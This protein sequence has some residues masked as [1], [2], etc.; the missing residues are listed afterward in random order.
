LQDKNRWPARRHNV[1]QKSA[2]NLPLQLDRSASEPLQDQ[3]FEKLRQLILSGRLKPNTRVIAT[4]F[5]AEQVGVSRRT[6]LFAYERLIAEGY[7]ETRPAIGT[8]VSPTPP[9]QAKLETAS[10]ALND[11][12]RQAALYPAS[13]RATNFDGRTNG[14]S[15]P[16]DFMP[17]R[18]DG[19]LVLPQ[20]IWL[21]WM[22]D[23][24]MSDPLVFG[25]PAPIGG[26][27][28]LREVIANYLGA[29]RGI[30]ASPDQIIIV[31]G[32][33]QAASL[34]AHLFQRQNDRVVVETP[35]DPAISDFFRLR[36]ASVM[37]VPVDS[38][39]LQI[40]CL[41]KGR[42]ALAYVT[43]ARQN[44]IGG[45]MPQSRRSEL[46]EWAREAGAYLIEDDCDGDLRH[47]GA[48]QAP[49]A[50]LD[51]YGLVFH[52]GSFAKTLGAGLA[53]GYL[54]VPPE[55][56]DEILA[57][58]AMAN[59]GGQHFEQLVVSNLIAGG[60]YD[61]HL[62]RLRKIYL[63]R[64]DALILA[65]K[66]RLGDITLL[67]TECG[68]QMSWVLPDDVVSASALH[69]ATLARGVR[70]GAIKEEAAQKSGFDDRTIVLG[71]PDL[72]TDRLREGV[73]I[74]A[75]AYQRLR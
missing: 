33:R 34:V 38:E 24:M 30:L 23:T 11:V 1:V 21:R 48:A 35:G 45:I 26:A 73:A 12:P 29:T 52:V 71:Y 69:Q 16:I 39:G 41:P 59:E 72:S 17:L 67:G 28:S 65:L 8:F 60:E 19:S 3:L 25:R 27:E 31:S 4:R 22:R 58:K 7:L 47:Q 46:I 74:L 57:I 36:G 14:P 49:L 43:P 68:T 53:L 75:D 10:T 40:G 37:P 61:H 42:T 63:E 32:R 62:R 64:R 15:V 50:A 2:M 55:F 56:I 44:P 66:A 6:V 54:L 51:S 9:A 13:L 20:K 5:L 18:Q 70:V